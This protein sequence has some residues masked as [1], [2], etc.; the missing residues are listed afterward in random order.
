M[1]C[2][3]ALIVLLLAI[4]FGRLAMGL[5]LIVAFSFGLAI[6]LVAVGIAVVRASGEIRKRIGERSPLL[7]GLPVVSSVLITV[8]GAWVVLW[9]LL[10]HN[11][12]VFMP[13]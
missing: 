8:L 5:W 7:L 9:T 4:K 6:V 3:A 2:P 10:Q 1:P 11:V 13:G 12:I